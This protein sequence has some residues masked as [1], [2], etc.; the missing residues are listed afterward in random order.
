M[1]EPVSTDS[2]T[3]YKMF[4]INKALIRDKGVLGTVITAIDLIMPCK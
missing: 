2:T 3:L 1:F 4:A